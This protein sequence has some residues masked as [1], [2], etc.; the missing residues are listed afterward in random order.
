MT[1]CNLVP[2]IGVN[3]DQFPSAQHWASWAGLGLCVGNHESVGKRISGKT[4]DGNK[5]LRR[6]LCQ[7]AWGASKKDCYLATQF[8]K[9]AARRGLKRAI[10]AVA[11]SIL[12]ICTML[13]TNRPY[14]QLGGAYLERS[15]K[16]NFSANT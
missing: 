3:M 16:I 10:I 13:K 12:I 11:Q 7:A 5:W 6:T 1:A 14:H 4:R 15:T 2:E 9:L 8:R